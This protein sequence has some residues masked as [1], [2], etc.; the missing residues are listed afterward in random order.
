[1]LELTHEQKSCH[2]C[3]YRVKANIFFIH[4]LENK[5]N[6]LKTRHITYEYFI[7]YQFHLLPKV[8]SGSMI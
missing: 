2:I 6:V 1:M 3:L 8:E 4:H 7:Y 5:M